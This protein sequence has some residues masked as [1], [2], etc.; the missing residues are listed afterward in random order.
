MDLGTFRTDRP[1]RSDPAADATTSREY[2]TVGAG[3]G[4]LRRT[5]PPTP[6]PG[7]VLV[8]TLVSGISHGTETLVHRGEVPESVADVMR[9][10]LQLG[11]LPH[12]VSHGY[13]AV[14]IVRSANGPEGERLIGRTVFCL[15]GH[16][17]H[18]AVPVEDCHP[19]PASCPVD[20]ALLA[21]IAE[22][23]LN[24]I[25]EAP[26]TLGD[27]LCVVGAGLVGLSTALLASRLSLERLQVVDVDAE[28]RDLARR[29]GLDAVAPE[30][31]R[32]DVDV[33]FHASATEDGLS[34]SLRLAGDDAVV[35]EQSWFGLTAPRAP[36]G[37]DFH[38]R[39][40]RLVASQVGEVA[41]PRRARRGRRERL[42]LALEML[43]ARF[44]ALLTGRSP[45]E[46][47]PAVM[48]ALSAGDPAWR[49]TL[50]HIV[51]HAGS[52]G[53]DAPAE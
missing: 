6:D 45:L 27:R 48:D 42:S 3:R 17:D 28:R 31:A 35:V 13:L 4:E 39:R 38:A 41:A 29:L 1:A 23:A 11:Q 40:L 2:W 10:P 14:G 22:P 12:P 36:L 52:A 20:R 25:W 46:D 18:L 30:E 32:D 47:L 44:D 43:D 21:G 15:G 9:A 49:S 26:A 33:V 19:L 7:E 50:C 8:E 53:R 24:A 34:T 51:D 16:R 37:A 5:T